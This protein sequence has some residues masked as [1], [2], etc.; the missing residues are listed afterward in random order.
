MRVAMSTQVSNTQQC[1]IDVLLTYA[2]VRPTNALVSYRPSD[3]EIVDVQLADLDSTVH[4]DSEH[5]KDGQHMVTPMFRSPEA[6][7]QMRWG[8]PTDIWSFGAMVSHSS[9]G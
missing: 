4:E 5:A 9:F 8:R 2:G 3:D 1:L 6:I 7:L